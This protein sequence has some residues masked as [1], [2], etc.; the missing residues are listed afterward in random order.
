MTHPMTPYHEERFLAELATSGN[1]AFACAAGR[2][3][4]S[5]AFKLRLEHP[6]FEKKWRKAQKVSLTAFHT[7][8]QKAVTTT[9]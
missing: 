1:I 8:L 7:R 9:A 5:D 2:I 3:S 6:E 4:R